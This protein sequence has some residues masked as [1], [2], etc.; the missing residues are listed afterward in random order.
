MQNELHFSLVLVR[1]S[2]SFSNFCTG[3][4]IYGLSE[5]NHKILNQLKNYHALCK[6]EKKECIVILS[7]Q[8]K[9]LKSNMSDTSNDVESIN[10]DLIKELT[11]KY[12]VIANHAC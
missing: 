4:H 8:N 2:A 1:L 7:N 5:F 10:M 9:K 6:Q 12:N 11:K 3:Q